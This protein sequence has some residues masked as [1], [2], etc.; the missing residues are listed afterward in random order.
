MF[1][2][3]PKILIIILLKNNVDTPWNKNIQHLN[4]F[5]SGKSLLLD[6]N[7]HSKVWAKIAI[8][9]HHRFYID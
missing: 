7:T 9:T 4:K 5:L 8:D 6:I 1:G 3:T 2:F